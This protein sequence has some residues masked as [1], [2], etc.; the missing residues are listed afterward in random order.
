MK[1]FSLGFILASIRIAYLHNWHLNS[2][3]V[4]FDN[5]IVILPSYLIIIFIAW[6]SILSLY[7]HINHRLMKYGIVGIC[8]FVAKFYKCFKS[9]KLVYAILNKC[10]KEKKK[11]FNSKLKAKKL[12]WQCLLIDGAWG[13]GKTTHYETY[14]KYIDANPNIYIRCFSA[15]RSELI[16]QIIQQ[17]LFYKL[18]TL[19]GILA[20]FMENNWQIFMPKGRVIVFDDLERLHANQD[21]YL[22]LIGI[23]DYLKDKMKCK[24]ILICNI[25]ELKEP[26]FNSYM[27]RIVDENEFPTLMSKNEFRDNLIKEPN[28]LTK[29]LLDRLYQDYASDK[30]NNLRIIKNIIPI[31]AKKLDNDYSKF[32]EVEQVLIGSYSQIIKLINKHYLFYTDNALFKKCSDINNGKIE[33]LNVEDE[34]KQEDELQKIL[35]KFKL[36]NDDFRCQRYKS[37]RDIGEILE[38]NFGDFLKLEIEWNL[39]SDDNVI[40]DKAIGIQNLVI[41]YL[42]KYVSG[43]TRNDFQSG[44][45]ALWFIFLLRVTK[46]TEHE[47][48]VDKILS[49]RDFMSSDNQPMKDLNS[50]IMPYDK[51]HVS[52]YKQLFNI[53]DFDLNGFLTVYYDFYRNKVIDKFINQIDE[54]D[55]DT[56]QLFGAS[57]FKNNSSSVDYGFIEEGDGSYALSTL[58]RIVNKCVN[59]YILN[60]WIECGVYKNILTKYYIGVIET[61]KRGV[62][63]PNKQ[64]I[65]TKIDEFINTDFLDVVKND[66]NLNSHAELPPLTKEKFLSFDEMRDKLFRFK[67]IVAEYIEGDSNELTKFNQFNQDNVEIIDKLFVKKTIDA[68]PNENNETNKK[69]IDL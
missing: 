54:I 59:L 17:R 12:N 65:K 44:D 13:S 19:N 56:L 50:I 1:I 23:I 39:K 66:N 36:E 27:E 20:R 29:K 52:K 37:W 69:T 9:Y 14:Y 55:D 46:H 43:N 33:Y 11:V 6:S 40:Y 45:Y 48:F 35:S 38:F 68:T 62:D 53:K 2:I 49:N 67:N 34:R 5:I 57:W 8:K 61:L 63:D 30:I 31:I 51:N 18:L 22:D 21:N 4:F 60:K 16:A 25:S 10:I 64:Y 28:E 32:N 24:I 7:K 3:K 47:R 41:Q 26:I 15:S 58:Y 42:E